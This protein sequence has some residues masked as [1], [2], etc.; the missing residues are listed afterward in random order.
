MRARAN[1]RVC[2]LEPADADAD[3]DALAG[4]SVV[5]AILGL[6]SYGMQLPPRAL[7][8]RSKQI[9]VAA[10]RRR[11]PLDAALCRA[12]CGGKAEDSPSTAV[13]H[14]LCSALVCMQC[15]APGT[16]FSDSR[17]SFG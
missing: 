10:H 1:A 11:G 6:R 2:A 17:L 14:A 3:A 8:G 4:R 12:H 16:C 7:M 15:M 9:G 5:G 13:L